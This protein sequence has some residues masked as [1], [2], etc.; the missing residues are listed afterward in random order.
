MLSKFEKNELYI[1]VNS[2]DIRIINNGMLA[3]Q[4]T[5]SIMELGN[6]IGG[7]P[8]GNKTDSSLN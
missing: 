6:C 7:K 2:M 4:K 8:S 3:M 1:Y 5:Y